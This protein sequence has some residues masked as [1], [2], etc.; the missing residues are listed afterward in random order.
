M[1]KMRGEK[2]LLN[3]KCSIDYDKGSKNKGLGS[4][5]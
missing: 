3:L 1:R 5:L 4:D 2:E